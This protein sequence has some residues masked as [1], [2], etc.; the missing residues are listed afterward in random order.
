M[1]ELELPAK[2]EEQGFTD[3]I[4]ENSSR[5]PLGPPPCGI[6]AAW[7]QAERP[8]GRTGKSDSGSN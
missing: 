1:T 7:A 5:R 2:I 4:R 8:K 6:E 3:R